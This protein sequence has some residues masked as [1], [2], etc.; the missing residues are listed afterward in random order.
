MPPSK[1]HSPY[2][3]R[4]HQN[5]DDQT[6]SKHSGSAKAI[7]ILNPDKWGDTDEALRGPAPKMMWW[8]PG[9]RG[10]ITS[11]QPDDGAQARKPAAKLVK[12]IRDMLPA[13]KV[14]G[15][16][17]QQTAVDLDRF[18]NSS[19]AVHNTAPLSTTQI[20]SQSIDIVQPSVL[21]DVSVMTGE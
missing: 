14:Y 11:E 20:R 8:I 5:S 4:G 19:I 17:G 6:T 16:T 21:S 7:V 3:R 18:D 13:A 2:A 9:Q 1:I 12:I 15:T 10:T